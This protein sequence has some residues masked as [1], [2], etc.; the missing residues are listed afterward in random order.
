MFYLH[1]FQHA[2]VKDSTDNR[3]IRELISEAKADVVVTEEEIDDATRVKVNIDNN[4]TV[5]MNNLK[6]FQS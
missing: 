6:T 3:P 4:I 2:F 5:I 1:Y